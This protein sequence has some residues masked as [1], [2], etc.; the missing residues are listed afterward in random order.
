[1]SRRKWPERIVVQRTL[2][3]IGLWSWTQA[4]E[5]R[6]NDDERVY[7]LVKPRKRKSPPPPVPRTRE[8]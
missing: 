6:L 5:L 7:Q 2:D 8:P 1:M 4:D 3:G